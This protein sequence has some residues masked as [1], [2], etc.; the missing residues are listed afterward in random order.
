MQRMKQIHSICF[1]TNPFFSRSPNCPLGHCGNL[2]SIWRLNE[3]SAKFQLKQ[4][5]SRS[6]Y[7]NKKWATEDC[8]RLPCYVFCICLS[9]N[10][11]KHCLLSNQPSFSW[12]GR[13][14]KGS[15]VDVCLTL[16][17]MIDVTK[18][19]DIVLTLFNIVLHCRY[20]LMS[21][22]CVNPVHFYSLH[23]NAIPTDFAC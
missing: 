7:V 18:L 2:D 17:I 4:G 15:I 22:S 6:M 9:T 23:K 5:G 12:S 8:R 10:K 21:Q 13:S 11:Y 1:L 3:Q 19:C 20:R 16:Q 14:S